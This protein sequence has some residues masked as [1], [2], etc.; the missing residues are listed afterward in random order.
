M[1]WNNTLCYQE[2]FLNHMK[3]KIGTYQWY[4]L[5][6]WIYLNK[7]NNGKDI[8]YYNNDNSFEGENYYN[9]LMFMFI[10]FRINEITIF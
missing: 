3:H 5:S 4:Y 2:E 9:G 6:R 1:R 7:N 8:I 10:L